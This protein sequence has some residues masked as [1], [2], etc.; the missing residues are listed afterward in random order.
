MA[1]F[2]P[3]PEAEL[4]PSERRVIR[5]RFHWAVLFPDIVQ[6]VFGVAVLYA[7]ARISDPDFWLWQSLLWYGAVALVIRL[8]FHMFA[9]WE[10]VIVFTNKRVF[11]VSGVLKRDVVQM[12]LGKITDMSAKQSL[13]ERLVGAGNMRFESAGQVQDLE[14]LRWLPNFEALKMAVNELIYGEKSEVAP[15]GSPRRRSKL[16]RWRTRRPQTVP[17]TDD[18]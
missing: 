11:K 12:P 17:P 14:H 7:L 5:V 18:D 6:S 4:V 2:G 9:W 13:L 3:P 10:E 15:K 8:A 1:L 16:A